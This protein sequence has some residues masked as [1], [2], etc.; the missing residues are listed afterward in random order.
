MSN[1]DLPTSKIE[2]ENKTIVTRYTPLGVAVAIIP[3]NYP[4]FLAT[5]KIAPCLVTGNTMIVKP[6]PFTPCGGLKLVELG[7]GFF[8]PGVLQVL[9]G[10]DNLGP[11]LTKS[12]YSGKDFVYWFYGYGQEGYGECY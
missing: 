1:L 6:S 9:S 3:C 2:E 4:I 11:W 10:D 7:Q 5:G 12:F 8:P